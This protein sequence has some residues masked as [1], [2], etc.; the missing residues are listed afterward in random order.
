[1]ETKTKAVLVFV[2]LAVV[3][4]ALFAMPGFGRA[5]HV[6]ADVQQHMNQTWNGSNAPEPPWMNGSFNGTRPEGFGRRNARLNN[7]NMPNATD[8]ANFKQAVVSS[9][10]QTAKTLNQEYGLGGPIFSKLN[11]TTFQ[12]Y[13][14]IQTLRTELMKELGLD[15]VS[16]ANVHHRGIAPMMNKN[17]RRNHGKAIPAYNA[18][19]SS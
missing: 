2:F 13:A 11:E 7:T 17:A 18:T 5:Y 4:G 10:F 6:D 16:L 9:D 8:I 15:N 14:Q 12:T 1:M 19:S 3:A